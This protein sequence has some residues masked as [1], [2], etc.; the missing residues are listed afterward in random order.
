MYH[1]P[2]RLIGL[3]S[4]LGLSIG[5]FFQPFFFF[6]LRRVSG[7]VWLPTLLS[8][9][10]KH[11]S[12]RGKMTRG[13]TFSFFVSVPPFTAEVTSNEKYQRGEKISRAMVVDFL[14]PSK[15]E[16]KKILEYRARV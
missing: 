15:G 11:V 7:S 13:R 5:P 8:E 3:L 16:K 14:I 4:S 1:Y 9:R 10:Q 12:A 6:L 2:S